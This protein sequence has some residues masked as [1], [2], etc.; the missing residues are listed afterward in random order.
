MLFMFSETG[1]SE[2]HIFTELLKQAVGH[3]TCVLN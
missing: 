2:D 3:D 1:W